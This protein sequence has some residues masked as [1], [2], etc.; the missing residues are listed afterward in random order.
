MCIRDRTGG[1]HYWCTIPRLGR[2]YGS[3]EMSYMR[4]NRSPDLTFRVTTQMRVE[5]PTPRRRTRCQWTGGVHYWCTIPRLG[6]I[7]GS[8]EMSYMRT[9]RSPDLTFRVA[10][11]MRAAQTRGMAQR[12]LGRPFQPATDLFLS[13]KQPGLR[14]RG[15]DDSNRR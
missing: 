1:V 13:F 6:R 15:F 5:L 4:T 12:I 14:S 2:I 3:S 8:S 9:N 11:Q 7:Y 10:T